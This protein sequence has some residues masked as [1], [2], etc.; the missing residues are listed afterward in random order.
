MGDPQR[1]RYQ[2]NRQQPE[3][4]NNNNNNQQ[5]QPTT[6]STQRHAAQL[7]YHCLSPRLQQF[8]NK[9]TVVCCH[10]Y[11]CCL[12]GYCRLFPWLQCKQELLSY[13]D[14]DS[15]K[16][17]KVLLRNDR[18]T[19]KLNNTL[20]TS[21]RSHGDAQ[22]PDTGY[23]QILFYNNQLNLSSM[24]ITSHPNYRHSLTLSLSAG[25]SL[26]RRSNRNLL[27]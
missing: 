25:S 21:R 18:T 7:V 11:L 12:Y 5:Q 3:T 27:K 15:V 8:V 23:L 6:T 26:R 1:N 22:P 13:H 10:G 9:V 24:Q 19:N 16:N 20:F 17:K 14:A 4:S 2:Q